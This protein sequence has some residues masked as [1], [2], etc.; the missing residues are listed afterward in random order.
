MKKKCNS[1]QW[2]NNDKYLCVCRKRHGC[3]KDYIWNPATCS[4]RNGKYLASVTDNSAITCDEVI[5]AEPKSNNEET[6]C[7]TNFNEN[8]ITYKTRNFC[9]YLPFY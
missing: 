8:S 1:D 5:D 4:C 6:S 3:K 7:A 9:I 2:W